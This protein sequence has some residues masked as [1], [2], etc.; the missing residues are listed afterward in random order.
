VHTQSAAGLGWGELVALG[1]LGAIDYEAALKLLYE[2]GL[3][4]EDAWAREPWYALAVQGLDP[5]SLD[6]KLSALPKPPRRAA[7]IAPD[8]FVLTGDEALLKKLHALLSQAGRGVKLTEVEPGWQWPHPAL[9]EVGERTAKDLEALPHEHVATPLQGAV[10]AEAS[11]QAREWPQRAR[12]HSSESLDWPA[13]GRR[14]RR[15]GMDTA[16]EVGHGSMLGLALHSADHGVRV[17]STEDGAAFAQAVKL[18]N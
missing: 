9:A 6:A 17:L 12:L 4:V 8:H 16:V 1:A 3:R 18:S 5:G 7:L 15:M 11:R 13:A 14:L 2:R 10:D